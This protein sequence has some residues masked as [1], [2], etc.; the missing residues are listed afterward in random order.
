MLPSIEGCLHELSEIDL[1]RYLDPTS[2]QYS[3]Q[4][5][6]LQPP[7]EDVR[8]ERVVKGSVPA[9]RFPNAGAPRSKYEALFDSRQEFDCLRLS[10]LY[11]AAGD[12]MSS[13]LGAVDEHLQDNSFEPDA[14][15]KLLA[16]VHGFSC[17]IG[18]GPSMLQAPD[19]YVERAWPV[20]VKCLCAR[21]GNFYVS[22]NELLLICELRKKNCRTFMIADGVAHFCG[23]VL[24]H[25]LE[26]PVLVGII[27]AG[28][29]RG[30][31]RSHFQRFVLNAHTRVTGLSGAR[32]CSFAEIAAAAVLTAMHSSSAYLGS[33]APFHTM[34]V[35][36]LVTLCNEFA[37]EA[38][39]GLRSDLGSPTSLA[40]QSSPTARCNDEGASDTQ[41]RANQEQ[42]V[43]DLGF[44]LAWLGLAWLCLLA[45]R[46]NGQIPPPCVCVCLCV[47]DGGVCG[48]V[49]VFV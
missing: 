3:S 19:G 28:G 29:V 7:W 47:G 46:L 6:F 10:F 17:V 42:T 48:W 31:I 16:F 38:C 37:F 14:L 8:G 43:Y 20:F 45:G 36:Q 30:R 1:E 39:G 41:A 15:A 40:A 5:D 12:S 32:T 35:S 22:C 13:L 21:N 49:R 18:S 2:P 25:G 44:L 11:T 33:S 23:E 26:E 9:M 24:G 34:T 4:I 27:D